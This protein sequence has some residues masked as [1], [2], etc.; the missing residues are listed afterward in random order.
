MM[1]LVAEQD[2]CTHMY[3]H[4]RMSAHDKSNITVTYCRKMCLYY[5]TWSCEEPIGN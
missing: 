4:F 2:P 5:V 1:L 3:H